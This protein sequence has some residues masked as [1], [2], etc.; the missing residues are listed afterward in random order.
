MKNKTTFIT[1]ILCL[2]PLVISMAVY[3]KLPDQIAIHFDSAGNPDSYLPKAIA[4]FGL[5]V[6]FML[7]NLYTHFRVNQDPKVSNASHALKNVSRW[8]VPCGIDC[9]CADNA[10]LINGGGDSYSNDRYGDGWYYHCA[11]RQLSAQV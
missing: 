1:T 7:I 5:P 3:D 9:C 8:A 10:L 2:L 4:A 6:L 11:L